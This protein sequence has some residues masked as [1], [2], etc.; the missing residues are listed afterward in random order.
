[1]KKIIKKQI[2]RASGSSF[3]QE[4]L[5]YIL[6]QIQYL[7]GIGSGDYVE[8]SG[9]YIAVKKMKEL[10]SKIDYCIFD[11]GANQGNFVKLALPYF[12]DKESVKI[13]CFEPSR[14]TFG[15]LS[16]NLSGDSRVIL[17]NIGISRDKGESD[18]FCNSEGSWMSSLTKR[19]LSH[20]SIDFSKSEKV[21]IDTID[22]YCLEKDIKQIDLLKID[23]EGHELD[24]LSG[25]ERMFKKN[26][27]KIVS[28]E[29]GGCAID[30][31]IF[32][33]DF[34]SYFT[35]QKMRIYR[36]T[37]SGY[38]FPVTSYKESLEQ[39]ITTNFLAVDNSLIL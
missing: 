1:M 22:N 28:F 39:F 29:F 26:S 14:A 17:N 33:R 2:I 32:F 7:M 11:V 10:L 24:V 38:L 15:K 35:K 25:A 20:L 34:Y 4:V 30:T 12:S 8:E 36:I 6:Y 13:H 3:S 23:V 5:N 9:E 27:I 19:D 18:L 21:L 31:R 37:P 16:G